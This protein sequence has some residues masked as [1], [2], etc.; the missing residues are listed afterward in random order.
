MIIAEADL[1]IPHPR[2]AERKFILIPLAEIAPLFEDPST[3][4]SM[5][6]LLENCEDSS[7]VNRSV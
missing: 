7:Q 3:G 5:M 6:A 1:A 2:I 4:K